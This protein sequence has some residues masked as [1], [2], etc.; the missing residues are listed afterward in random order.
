MGFSM[1]KYTI[2]PMDP[3]WV[4]W[5]RKPVP[6]SKM[7]KLKLS[8]GATPS[9]SKKK[10]D[11][12]QKRRLFFSFAAKSC[13]AG[14]PL[15]QTQQKWFGHFLLV[16]VVS[17]GLNGSLFMTENNYNNNFKARQPRKTAGGKWGKDC[18]KSSW[19][20]LLKCSPHSGSRKC[21]SNIQGPMKLS[22]PSSPKFIN[23]KWQASKIWQKVLQHVNLKKQLDTKMQPPRKSSIWRCISYWK[24]GFINVMLVFGGVRLFD[25]PGGVSVILHPIGGTRGDKTTQGIHKDFGFASFPGILVGWRPFFLKVWNACFIS[26]LPD[27]EMKYPMVFSLLRS[28]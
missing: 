24:W 21:G 8:I 9:A 14:P 10:S 7:L 2:R 20:V 18:N 27:G 12:F 11:L 17:W 16:V 4:R 5:F 19:M 22:L 28:G 1:G 15:Y 23:G 25:V 26:C 13:S 6:S 3:S